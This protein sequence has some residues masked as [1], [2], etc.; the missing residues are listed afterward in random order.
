MKK[1][2]RAAA[3]VVLIGL[4]SG[5]PGTTTRLGCTRN[6]DGTV[7]CHVEFHRD[8]NHDKPVPV[9]EAPK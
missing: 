5:C 6:D 9:V 3:L 4:L 1:I 7:E 2:L 8:G